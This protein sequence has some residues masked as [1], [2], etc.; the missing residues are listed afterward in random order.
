MLFLR[1]FLKSPQIS[2]SVGMIKTISSSSVHTTPTTPALKRK[3]FS[4]LKSSEKPCD[5]VLRDMEEQGFQISQVDLNRWADLLDKQGHEKKYFE[6]F[7][8][9]ESKCRLMMNKS[10]LH[11]ATGNR[12]SL[13]V[14][15]RTFRRV[16]Q[17]IAPSVV[18]LDGPNESYGSGILFGE[19]GKIITCGHIV[20]NLHKFSVSP[21]Y[22]SKRIEVKITLNCGQVFRG[23]VADCD[24][25]Y[26]LA[27]VKIEA[28][29][30]ASFSPAKF[31]VSKDVE[32]GDMVL[33]IGNPLEFAN[34]FSA[35]IISS[36][37]RTN[38]EIGVEGKCQFYFQTD[39]S[40]N[41]GNSGG[42]VV[43]LEGEVIGVNCAYEDVVGVGFAMP[44]DIVRKVMNERNW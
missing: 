38:K 41:E 11:R 2:S 20:V 15:R 43:N 3:L 6:I 4:N 5:D 36:V 19:E 32:V 7:S 44:I 37:R 24:V 26:D 42:P 18:T 35:G 13:F 1:R 29:T 9:M 30:K 23:V 27:L 14:G 25:D 28:P 12:S 17:I 16:A 39:C 21:V 34:S 8:F 40:L 22:R 31:G 33:S 10:C